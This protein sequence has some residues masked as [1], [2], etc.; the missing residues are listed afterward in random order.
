MQQDRNF[1]D[2]AERFNARIYDTLKGQ[3]RLDIL[4][5][6]L[7]QFTRTH[8]LKVWDAGCGAGQIS[9][10]LAGFG[11]QMTLC[12]ISAKLLNQAQ[13]DFAEAKLQADFH[14]T[15]IQQ[16]PPQLT[17]FDLVICH[18]VVEW[19]ATPL[20]TLKQVLDRVK[21]RGYLSLMFYNRNAMVY[22]NVIRGGWRLEPILNDRYIGVGN[23]LSPPFPQYPNEI[24]QFLQNNDFEIIQHSGI[25]VFSDYL[26]SESR[27]QT[28][29]QEL[30]AL[31]HQY[32]RQP[33]YRDMGR[34]VHLLA[35]KKSPNG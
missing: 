15:S 11:H 24:I 16:F 29:E 2:L 31:E 21:T 20:E 5:Q 7:E 25:R 8:S 10:W 28:N 22:K 32:C 13:Q 6:D 17:Q 9:L 30:L 33:T 18:A 23:K 14:H 1:D 34:Y 35:E 12:D 4:K 3:L 27:N 19:L 26:N